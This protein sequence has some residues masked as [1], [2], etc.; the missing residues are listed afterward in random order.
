MSNLLSHRLYT[1]LVEYSGNEGWEEFVA[2]FP[3]LEM[4]LYQRCEIDHDIASVLYWKKGNDVDRLNRWLEQPVPALDGEAP[5]DILKQPDGK[6][7]LRSLIMR[8][9]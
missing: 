5:V 4:Q 2:C 3:A 1:L 6:A 7:I 9:P 8:M